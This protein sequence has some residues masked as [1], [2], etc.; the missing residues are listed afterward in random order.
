VKITQHFGLQNDSECSDLALSGRKMKD[1][2]YIHI[3]HDK[4]GSSAIQSFLALNC[5]LFNEFDIDYPSDKSFERARHGHL[6]F[7]NPSR[8][9][10]A[11]GRK[12]CKHQLFSSEEFFRL[13]TPGTGFLDIIKKIESE[14]VFICYGR[15]LFDH[16]VSRYGENVK[17]GIETGLIE[18]YADQYKTPEK[19]HNVIKT[20]LSIKAKLILTNYSEVKSSI[21]DHFTNIV[22]GDRAEEFLRRAQ[23]I[24]RRVNRS[25]TFTEL[26]IQRLFNIYA[27]GYSASF[28]S[29]NL[30]NILPNEI[31]NR[32]FITKETYNKIVSKNIKYIENNNQYIQGE[33]INIEK[34]EDKFENAEITN[35]NINQQQIEVIVQSVVQKIN[36]KSLSSLEID[37]LRDVAVK[38]EEKVELNRLDALALMKIAFR[39]RPDGNF[40]RKK[41]MEWSEN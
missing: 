25:L 2:V 27:S 6:S 17:R 8:I 37:T 7:G 18:D 12:R 16:F 39:A 33:K 21:E 31:E 38:I 15:N 20:I 41:V 35:H 30:V 9:L 40:I 4:T 34:Y 24:D 1:K 26:E 22:L 3:G 23:Y 36:E 5:D 19:L 10:D 14:V 28:I 29:E 32:V 13:V 11:L